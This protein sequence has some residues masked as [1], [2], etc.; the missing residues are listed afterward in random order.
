MFYYNKR[1]KRID[2]VNRKPLNLSEGGM[3]PKLPGTEKHPNDDT[4][5]ADLEAGS[6]VIPVPV[7]KKGV[8]KDYKGEV[9]G[10]IQ[11]KKEKLVRA[12]VMPDEKVIHRK[13]APKVERFLARKGIKLPLGS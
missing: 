9:T 3:I 2:I 7:M 8:M 10:P 12:I 13:H 6:L 1:G 4:I 11:R 5:L